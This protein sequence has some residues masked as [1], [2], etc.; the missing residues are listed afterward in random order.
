MKNFEKRLLNRGHS[1]SVVEKHLSEF[2]F[3]DRKAS[4]KEKDRDARTRLLPFVTQYHLALPN[5]KTLLM[6]KWHLIQIQQQLRE[7]FTE[8]PIISY[9]QRKSL[10]DIVVRTKL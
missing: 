9:R 3:N 6:R 1:A 2:K 8:P 4:L 5:L 7:I 10:K